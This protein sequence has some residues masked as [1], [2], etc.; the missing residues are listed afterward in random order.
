MRKEL[1]LGTT[2]LHTYITDTF[3]IVSS[4]KG[5]FRNSNYL[6]AS[7]LTNYSTQPCVDKLLGLT[8]YREPWLETPFRPHK[9]V[10]ASG[11]VEVQMH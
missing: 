11:D 3:F 5:L 9:Q 6:K 1:I 8:S 4:P 2:V 10:H 7:H